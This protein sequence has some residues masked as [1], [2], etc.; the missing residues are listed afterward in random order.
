MLGFLCY[1][2]TFVAGTFLGLILAALVSTQRQDEAYLDGYMRGVRDAKRGEDP[3][4]EEREK[5]DKVSL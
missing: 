5:D 1:T 4:A 3:A 2:L